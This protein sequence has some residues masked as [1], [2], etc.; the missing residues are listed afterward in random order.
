MKFGESFA[1]RSVPEWA[2]FNLHYNA[3]KAF[4]KQQTSASLA[5]PIYIPQQ[6]KSRWQ[7]S[8]S[9]LFNLLRD[10]YDNIA[11]FLR[12]KQGEIDRRLNVLGK[13]IASLRSY[14][15]E[16]ALEID[17]VASMHG[18]KYRKLN[19]EVD[20]LGDLIQKVAR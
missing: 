17:V 7:D 14:V 9:A 16:R 11:L 13:Q 20:E 2:A 4:V 10:Q 3:I 8:D 6:G 5:G 18:R 12:M 19:K 15:D 1:Q